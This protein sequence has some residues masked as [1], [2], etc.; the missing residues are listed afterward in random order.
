[1]SQYRPAFRRPISRI[2]RMTAHAPVA[3]CLRLGVHP[4][5]VSLSSMVAGGLAG[6]CF[7]QVAKAPIL[8]LVGAG[9]CIVRLWLNML[10][11]M[12][13]LASGKASRRGEIFN[14]VPD[15]FSDV[16]IFVGVAHSGLCHPMAGYWAAIMALA[17]AY[18]GTLGQAVGARREFGG[19][20]SKPWRMAAVIAGACATWWSLWRSN[21]L[22]EWTGLTLLDW[23]CLLVVLGCVQTIWLR[24][25]RILR[26]L[27]EL[28]GE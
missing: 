9:L 11:G 24:L 21:G 27:D 10:D 6:A 3:A 25:A 5:L 2:F 1:M 15:R 20:M 14:E 22:L 23:I 17:T 19:V 18:V 16:A 7:W 4:D 8:L 28:E 12:V 13:A 26:R